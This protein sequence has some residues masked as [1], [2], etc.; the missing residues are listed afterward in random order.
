MVRPAWAMSRLSVSSSARRLASPVSASRG[1]PGPRR[2]RGCAPG[3]PAW[4]AAS[5]T[6]P[7]MRSSSAAS[8]VCS[9]TAE[10]R[11]PDDL[12]AD[13]QRPARARP[14]PA[15]PQSSHSRTSSPSGP[16]LVAAA[17]PHREARAR[18][19]RPRAPRRAA[20]APRARSR[21]PG[22]PRVSPVAVQEHRAR[23]G[24]P[25][26]EVP[27]EQPVRLALVGGHLQGLPAKR[28]LRA[29][30]AFR[31]GRR[32][33]RRGAAVPPARAGCARAGPR[34]R[35]RT[36]ARA[37]AVSAT[38][39]SPAAFPRPGAGARGPP[40]SR[41]WPRGSRRARAAARRAPASTTAARRPEDA[42]RAASAPSSQSSSAA[43][44]TASRRSSSR[45]R[46]AESLRARASS[47]STRTSVCM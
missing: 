37:R 20:N 18:G 34:R 10:H 22:G 16:V 13:E 36:A 35:R 7:S 30:E 8:G 3:W 21:P 15:A 1:P 43:C 14:T 17:E 45:A 31:A 40:G 6:K 32:A 42:S 23:A 4:A 27:D 38:G 41:R 28:S 9:W 33:G 26:L 2:W 29:R 44:W 47:A 5:S 46:P 12:P 24:S 11:A 25:A 39:I 19:A